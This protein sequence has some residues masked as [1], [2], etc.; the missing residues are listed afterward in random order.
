MMQKGSEGFESKIHEQ[1]ADTSS[2]P[3]R[4]TIKRSSRENFQPGKN[5]FG[6]PGKNNK[7][8]DSKKAEFEKIKFRSLEGREI[9]GQPSKD[10]SE[11]KVSKKL[12]GKQHQKKKIMRNKEMTIHQSGW[13]N[14]GSGTQGSK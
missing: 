11:W 14:R 5:G 12:L 10:T 3:E 1:G 2:N 4:R 9:R 7:K 6:S 8:K 13:R